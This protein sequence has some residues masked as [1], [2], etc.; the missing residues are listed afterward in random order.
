[1]AKRPFSKK[2]VNAPSNKYTMKGIS[3][4]I[5]GAGSNASISVSGVN[6]LMPPSSISPLLSKEL[7]QINEANTKS[8]KMK[9][10]QFELRISIFTCKGVTRSECNKFKM[11]FSKN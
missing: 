7:Q 10:L 1:M 3:R 4:Q 5:S 11:P 2:V 8:K 6:E 9:M